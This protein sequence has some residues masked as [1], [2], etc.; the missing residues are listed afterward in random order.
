MGAFT[1]FCSRNLGF[2]IGRCEVKRRIAAPVTLTRQGHTCTLVF[3]GE[4]YNAKELKAQLKIQ[5]KTQYDEECLLLSYMQDGP[6]FV[7]KVNGIFGAAIWDETK[8]TLF[9]FRDRIGAKPMFY[10]QKKETLFFA[11]SIAS[12]FQYPGVEPVLDENGLCEVFALG[13]A[14]TPGNGVFAGISEV[15]PGHYL[16]FC[17]GVRTEHCYWKLES[18][19][20]EDSFE[21]TVEKTAWLLEDAVTRQMRCKENEQI[22]ALLSG[23]VDSSLVTA[24]CGENLQKR[25]KVLQTFSFD[26]EGNNQY[27]QANA[28]QPSQDRPWVEKMTASCGSNHRYLECSNEQLV[29]YLDQAVEARCLPCMADVESSMLYFCSRV[30]EHAQV[31]LT[32]ECADEIFGGYP[33]FHKKE[34]FETNGFPW[35]SDQTVRQSLLSD[36][37]VK[38]LQM[39]EYAQSAYEQSV[40]ETPV[41]PEDSAQEKR[42]REIAYL[43]LKWF[44][45]TLLDRM[46]RTSFYWNLSAR[47]PIADYRIIEYVW[48]VPWDMKCKDGIPKA[49]LRCAGKGKVPDEVLWRKK[50]PYPKTYH[51]QYESL[52]AERFQR[53][54]LEDKN[55]PIREFL[56]RKKAERFLNSPKDYGKPWYGQLMAGPQMIAYM[57]QVNYWMEHYQI[58]IRL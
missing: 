50:S 35:S 57:M 44:M 43:N 17:D 25:G 5:P 30:A 55:A 16:S 10:T 1:G 20:H 51:P 54:V 48:N 15:L 41:C 39:Q 38:K 4:L 33:W 6:E 18:H 9:L 36:K 37:W 45:A 26:F 23:G 3:N 11:S 13:P 29:Q 46:E 52:L 27:F 12:L 7:Q 58:R 42:R 34:A 19:S 28:F 56:D 32:G 40:R 8:Q 14:R 21:E 2:A 49:L 53:E 31:V 24:I 22:A 47:V